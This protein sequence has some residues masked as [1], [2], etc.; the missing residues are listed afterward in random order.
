[1][2]RKSENGG[3]SLAYRLGYCIRYAALHLFGP[4]ALGEA[5]DPHARLRRE[6]TARIAAARPRRDDTTAGH[7]QR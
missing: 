1:M 3:L 2:R 7:G 5:D 6:R 4:A